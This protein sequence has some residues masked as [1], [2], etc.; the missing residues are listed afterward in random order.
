M[1]LSVDFIRKRTN[2]LG[3]HRLLRQLLSVVLLDIL[4]LSGVRHLGL[5]DHRLHIV[6]QLLHDVLVLQLSYVLLLS[7]NVCIEER[8][9]L[10]QVHTY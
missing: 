10:K 5:I 8:T 9:L 1:D 3:K 4:K 7:L 6:F 2:V